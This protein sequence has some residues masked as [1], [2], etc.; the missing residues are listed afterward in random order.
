MALRGLISVKVP[1]LKE[2][3]RCLDAGTARLADGKG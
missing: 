3:S 2:L 1:G